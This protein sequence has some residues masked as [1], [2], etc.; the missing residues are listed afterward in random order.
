MLGF[1]KCNRYFSYY[2]T[3][4][5]DKVQVVAL[6]FNEKVEKWFNNFIVWQGFRLIG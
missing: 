6:Y 4:D 2:A 5:R 3:P 1:G